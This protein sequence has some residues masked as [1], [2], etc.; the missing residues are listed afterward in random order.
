MYKPASP[1]MIVFV[2]RIY[3]IDRDIYQPK[4]GRD[5]FLGCSSLKSIVL[6]A[7]VSEIDATAFIGSSIEDIH[8]DD[9]NPNYCASG[10]FLIEVKGMILIR[11]FGNEENIIESLTNVNLR[12]IGPF[13]FSRRST[14]KSIFLP[15]CIEILAEERFGDCSSLSEVTFEPGSKLAEIGKE[16][17]ISCCS[18]ASICIPAEVEQIPDLCF[19]RCVRSQKDIRTRFQTYSDLRGGI[20][21]TFISPFDCFSSS[22]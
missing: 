9:E 11:Y 16:A 7:A 6:P 8:V 19:S 21:S 2:F 10:R 20:F 15:A 14:L 5:V 22:G 4:V 13:G 1:D 3:A 17:F 18:L 12:G